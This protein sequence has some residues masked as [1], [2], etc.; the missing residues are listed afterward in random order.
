M[1]LKNGFVIYIGI[2]VFVLLILFLFIYNNKK[3]KYRGGKKVVRDELSN[4]NPVFRRRMRLYRILSFVIMIACMAGIAVS[5]VI[6]ARPVETATK[7]K[8]DNNRDIILSIDVSTSVDNLN[9]NLVE[10]LKKTVMELKGE[11]FGI[12]IF[13]TSTVLLTPLTDDYEFV[14]KQLDIIKNAIESRN[15]EFNYWGNI[16]F[17]DEYFYYSSYISSGTLVGAEERGS[18][19]IGDGLASTV[20]NFSKDDDR[21]RIVIFST[22]NDV[23]GDSLFSLPAAA[24]Y[25]KENDVIVYGI[26]TKEMYAEKKQEMK[27][28]VEATGGRFFLEEASG[29]NFD[30][31]VSDIDKMSKSKVITGYEVIETD[32][33]AVP[34]IIL[35]CSVCT[36]FVMIKITRR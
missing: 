14:I 6:L 34:F 5:F 30:K 35:L 19:L 3:S 10:K 25:C 24:R 17:D 27:E 28:C 15:M 33:S 31:I 8:T 4:D 20:P 7:E 16:D 21:T 11:R 22:D 18:S 32:K 29:K 13:N 26:G 2:G 12:Q 36:M 23:Q 1:E 9:M